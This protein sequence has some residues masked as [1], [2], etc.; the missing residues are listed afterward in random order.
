MLSAYW[1]RSFLI[2][3]GSR[4][5]YM[6]ASLRVVQ[7]PRERGFLLTV[8]NGEVD[9]SYISP[10]KRTAVKE[11]RRMDLKFDEFNEERKNKQKALVSGYL[12]LIAHPS[13]SYFLGC[14][15]TF[16]CRLEAAF[17]GSGS[18]RVV[19]ETDASDSDDS[20][21][22][23]P[24]TF[25][26]PSKAGSI[27]PKTSSRDRLAP[28]QP[29]RTTLKSAA[30]REKISSTPIN[31]PPAT[32]QPLV[33][34]IAGNPRK[35]RRSELFSGPGDKDSLLGTTFGGPRGSQLFN[36]SESEEGR[37]EVMKSGLLVESSPTHSSLIIPS[38]EQLTQ[39]ESPNKVNHT[40]PQNQEKDRSQ[41]KQKIPQKENRE[42]KV[43]ER[44]E[45]SD[46]K[47]ITRDVL[48]FMNAWDEEDGGNR[49]TSRARKVVN[50]AL[51]NLR[52][53]MRRKDRSVD[54][55][56]TPEVPS[57]SQPVKSLLKEI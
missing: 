21:E 15:L 6:I 30:A 42:E 47:D 43:G 19:S 52:D 3:R 28:H 5:I 31:P 4:I 22:S 9:L 8:G 1:N 12:P 17:T 53:K 38:A 39:I 37:H 50:Y 7:Y 13:L 29:K 14:M 10:K 2:S 40:A 33:E 51:P 25:S 44:Q 55:S 57:A 54:R 24:L 46:L 23:N 45:D 35:R 36:P 41:S 16:F 18:P 49:R 56:V 20:D 26:H 27:P 34:N 11:R 32:T 48:D